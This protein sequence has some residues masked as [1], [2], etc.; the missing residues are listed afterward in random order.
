ML[1]QRMVMGALL[2]LALGSGGSPIRAQEAAGGSEAVE[3]R[4]EGGYQAAFDQDEDVR[5]EQ[6]RD[7]PEDFVIDLL[8]L[9]LG[10]DG[11]SYYLDFD[12][13]QLL[14]QDQAYSLQAGRWG[15]ARLSIRWSQVP[16]L[17]TRSAQV[18]QDRTDTGRLQVAD[19][20]QAGA[21][22]GADSTQVR[23][24]LSR[25]LE[26]TGTSALGLRQDTGE[27]R[28]EASP[29]ENLSLRAVYRRSRDHGSD[30]WSAG[31]YDRRSLAGTG[32]VWRIH[33]IE[34]REPVDQEQNELTLGLRLGRS[35]LSA[36]LSYS[37]S[38]YSNDIGGLVFDNPLWLTDTS[39]NLVDPATG[40][41]LRDSLGVPRDTGSLRGR[42]GR[43]ILSTPPDSIA[44][45][46]NLVL[47][48]RLGDRTNLSSAT[49]VGVILQDEEFLPYTVNTALRVFNADGDSLLEESDPL[50]ADYAPP[51]RD[52]NG[53]VFT[54]RE[55]A[56]LTSRLGSRTTLTARYRL[57]VWDNQSDAIVFPGYAAISD[58]V[59]RDRVSGVPV[60]NRVPAYTRHTA[61]VETRYRV[62]S[63]AEL[64]AL[65]EWEGWRRDVRNVDS[66]DEYGIGA[67]VTLKPASWA[68]LRADYRYG[69]RST[70]EYVG[71]LTYSEEFEELRAFDQA[72][73]KVHRVHSQ[74]QLQPDD[75]WSIGG[76]VRWEDQDYDATEFGRTG[77]ALTSF[78]VDVSYAPNDRWSLFAAFAHDADAYDVYLRAKSDVAG[79][80]TFAQEAN[81][82]FSELRDRTNLVTVGVQ[83]QLKP[84]KLSG[85]LSWVFSR[86]QASVD[87]VN[88]HL[89]PAT[90]NSGRAFPFPDKVA[91]THSIKA[92]LSWKLLKHTDVK[93]LYLVEDFQ[94]EDFQWD[95]LAPQMDDVFR[96]DLATPAT[97]DLTRVEFIN[98]RY[99]DS[100]AHLARVLLNYRF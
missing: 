53:K 19:E 63:K 52:L 2:G 96:P 26:A 25:V 94:L 38:A 45:S 24:V 62:S 40:A 6:L 13:W 29:A 72:E 70:S 51:Q 21:Q 10:Y 35:S 99:G 47:A 5:F 74:V 8:G 30:V 20:I 64:R 86:D 3:G 59:W 92:E 73:R 56:V 83:G 54:L 43:W 16:H 91:Q 49:S 58:S 65:G 55:T 75:R 84:D 27:F 90:S 33:A 32:E 14:Q 95:S 34:L 37:L 50:A 89:G 23:E 42:S 66:T 18:I 98:S 77:S 60:E 46:A 81:D 17:F 36:D 82:Y 12:G 61:S 57:N 76:S 9:K 28:I 67:G 1:T 22:A 85:G 11:R 41:V 71:H 39:A 78:G 69:T 87:T 48:L 4:L 79:G 44:H 97:N 80:G 31:L 7:V 93:L 88:P 15:K 68:S 100:S